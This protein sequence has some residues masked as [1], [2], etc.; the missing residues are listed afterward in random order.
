MRDRLIY[1]LLA[2]MGHLS[3]LQT[4]R[5]PSRLQIAP[6]LIEVEARLIDAVREEAEFR[7]LRTSVRLRPE[8]DGYSILSTIVQ[9]PWRYREGGLR[10]DL[11]FVFAILVSVKLVKICDDEDLQRETY[12]L[13][14]NITLATVPAGELN[15]TPIGTSKSSSR[16]SRNVVT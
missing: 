10:S 3:I 6:I 16:S 9:N 14:K 12:P 2:L 4:L 1:I 13:M 7:K 8:R 15:C 11:G 5:R